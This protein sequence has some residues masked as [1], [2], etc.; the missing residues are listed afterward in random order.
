[1]RFKHGKKASRSVANG[2]S[3]LQ[4]R[5]VAQS[6]IYAGVITHVRGD[7]IAQNSGSRAPSSLR[8]A[9]AGRLADEGSLFFT[10]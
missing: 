4:P 8:L 2:S 10:S 7:G 6:T 5:S 1:L 3:S 9:A